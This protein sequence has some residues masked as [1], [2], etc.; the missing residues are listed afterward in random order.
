[1]AIIKKQIPILASKRYDVPAKGGVEVA[2]TL[3][4]AIHKQTTN[5]PFIYVMVT[6]EDDKDKECN[7]KRI[8]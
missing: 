7:E 6:E 5:Q 4:A 2:C 3:C 8:R 1:M